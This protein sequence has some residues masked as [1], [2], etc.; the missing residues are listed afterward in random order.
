MMFILCSLAVYK[1]VQTIDAM[2][3]K[4]PMPWVKILASVALSYAAAAIGGLDNLIISGLSVAAVAGSV[5]AL[6]RL[7]MLAGDLA[8]RKSLR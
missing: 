3:P 6:L 8:Q 7:L 5:H 2:L 1:M 4:E